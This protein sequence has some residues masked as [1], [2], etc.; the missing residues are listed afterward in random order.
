MPL[1]TKQSH[2][3][4]ILKIFQ[5]NSCIFIK[6]LVSMTEYTITVDMQILET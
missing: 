2:E 1:T 3:P 6:R 4:F 5:A